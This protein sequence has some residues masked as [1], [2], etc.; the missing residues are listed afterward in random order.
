MSRS[1]T[2]CFSLVFFLVL[3]GLA[4][5]GAAELAPF[6]SVYCYCDAGAPCGNADDDAGCANVTGQGAAVNLCGSPSMVADDLV[7]SANGV[8]P[9]VSGLFYMGGGAGM[10]PVSARPTE[11]QKRTLDMHSS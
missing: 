4:P 9:N 8:L 5:A 7:I 2:M 6:A 3:L 11:N 10:Q 1:R